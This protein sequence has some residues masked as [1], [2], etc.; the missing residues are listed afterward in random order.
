MTQGRS[1]SDSDAL[2]VVDVQSDFC[3]NGALAVPRGH[4]VVPL[5]NRKAIQAD[6]LTANARQ[7]QTVYDYQRVVLDAF[8][9]VINRLAQQGWAFGEWGWTPVLALIF[10]VATVALW[11]YGARQLVTAKSLSAANSLST[12]CT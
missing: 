5:I 10:A 4:E 3:P 6:Y 8:T 12:T 1:I 2:L 7:L 9:Q 11:G